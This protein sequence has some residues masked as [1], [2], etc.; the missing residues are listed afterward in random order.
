MDKKAILKDTTTSAHS[1][2]DDPRLLELAKQAAL[3]MHEVLGVHYDESKGV[4]IG[5]IKFVV[6]VLTLPLGRKFQ[7]ASTKIR[8]VSS[9]FSRFPAVSG[10]SR[11]HKVIFGSLHSVIQIRQTL[12]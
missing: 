8:I 4:D 10:T 11:L 7:S 3:C 2:E 12:S 1:L 5:D 9:A 6:V